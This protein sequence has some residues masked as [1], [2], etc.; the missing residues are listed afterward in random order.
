M[1]NSGTG[2]ASG[3]TLSDPLPAGVA[4]VENPDVAQCS[5]TA[6]VLSRDWGT[7]APNASVSVTV[8]GVTDAADCGVLTNT[9]RVSAANETDTSDN[10]ATATV[11]VN[12]PDLVIT[13]TTDTGSIIAGDLARFTVTVTNSGP[14]T[15]TAVH[16]SDPLPAGI[17][18]VETPDVAECAITA[19]TLTCDWATLAPDVSVVVVVEGL[20][21]EADCAVLTNT[22]TVSAANEA[23]TGDNTATAT[24]TV[25]CLPN[26]AVEKTADNGTIAAGETAAFTITVTNVGAGDAQAVTLTDDLPDGI[27]WTADNELCEIADGV[28]ICEFGTMATNASHVVHLTGTT[29]VANCGV[30]T[31]TAVVDAANEPARAADA[32]DNNTSTATITVL[33]A[34]DI[35]IDKSGPTTAK[36][37]D[38]ITY[39]FKVTNVGHTPLTTVTLTDPICDGD[40]LT[41]TA[42]G[43]GDAV[44]AVGEVWTAMCAHVVKATDPD[45]LPNTATVT[46]TAA[47]GRTTP[48]RTDT[49]VVDILQPPVPTPRPP[50]PATGVNVLPFGVLGGM[51][52]LLGGVILGIT[53][54]RRR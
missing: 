26:V 50:L 10:S 7:L 32:E 33:C 54:P 2:T 4:W 8:E 28:L 21:D 34:V 44:L 16:L 13:K 25:T 11:T 41:Y 15:A 17:D 24:I 37:G 29:A 22:A 40:S 5:I 47:D 45:P 1:T 53:R 51:L 19:G 38:T 12:C 3:V 35:G 49:H 14:G 6:G 31:N 48:T 23:D 18:W 9:A 27:A 46:G 20:T 36:V 39:T 42:K 52:L 43:D 30:L